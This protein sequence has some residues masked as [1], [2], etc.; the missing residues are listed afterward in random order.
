MKIGILADSHDHVPNVEKA[1]ALFAAIG[2]EAVIHAGDFCSPFAIP[3]L[4]ALGKR[5]VAVFGNNDGERLGLAKRI[6]PFGEVQPNVAEASFGERRIAVTHYPEIAEPLALAGRHDLVVYG[7]THHLESRRVGST[8]VLN[9]G[10]AGGWLT[11]R[12]TVAVVDL[13]TLAVEIHDL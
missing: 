10:E 8:L 3:P 4:A 13:A 7:H 9:P 6:E 12:S 11:R 5:L 2:V 1:A